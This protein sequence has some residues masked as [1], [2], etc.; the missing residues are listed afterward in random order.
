MKPDVL[1]IKYCL[2]SSSELP[3]QSFLIEINGIE[4]C[5]LIV[6][7][8]RKSFSSG[9]CCRS[10]TKSP[11]VVLKKPQSEKFSGKN[12]GLLLQLMIFPKFST[13]H[14]VMIFVLRLSNSKSIWSSNNFQSSNQRIGTGI[15]AIITDFRKNH[16]NLKTLLHFL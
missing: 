16:K 12:P 14:L 10:A 11:E 4:N 13:W 3:Q 8:V 6:C 7:R 1:T 9:V 5:R 15:P 2:V